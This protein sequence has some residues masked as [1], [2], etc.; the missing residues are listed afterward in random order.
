MDAD[1]ILSRRLDALPLL[2]RPGAKQKCE[3]RDELSVNQRI[4]SEV[5]DAVS[6]TPRLRWRRPEIPE[7]VREKHSKDRDATQYVDERKSLHRSERSYRRDLL[8]R[9]CV[10]RESAS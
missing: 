4:A 6:A 10:Q 9:R 7:R 8:L 2:R 3:Y 1:R 5:H